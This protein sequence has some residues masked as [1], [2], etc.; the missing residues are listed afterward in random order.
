[1]KQVKDKITLAVSK[2]RILEE[3]LPL[4]ARAGLSPREDPNAE[5]KL[6]F[7][8][9]WPGAT[10]IIIRAA[11]VPVYVAFAPVR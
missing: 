9:D 5:R 4:L 6:I 3:S 2:G 7:Q 10:L 8:T 1:M 11:D